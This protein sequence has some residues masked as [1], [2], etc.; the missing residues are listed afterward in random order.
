M[1]IPHEHFSLRICFY[2]MRRDSLPVF[3]WIFFLHV[4]VIPILI[5][6]VVIIKCEEKCKNFTRI[7]LAAKK[8]NRKE[9]CVGKDVEWRSS[10]NFK[11]YLVFLRPLKPPSTGLLCTFRLFKAS[12]NTFLRKSRESRSKSRPTA[13][14]FGNKN[15]RKITRRDEK[16]IAEHLLSL[17][18][19]VS[20]KNSF[21]L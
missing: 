11:R 20:V 7:S 17:H 10:R 21:P 2:N 6:F 4:F 13:A 14:G 15:I 5:R 18:Y 12:R 1:R 19:C 8:V 3:F 16:L 9:W